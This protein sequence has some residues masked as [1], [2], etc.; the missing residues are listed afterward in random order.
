MSLLDQA[1]I[2]A[3]ELRETALRSAEQSILERYAPEVRKAVEGMLNEQEELGMEMGAEEGEDS[4]VEAP[5]AATEGEKLC[6]CPDEGEDVEVEIDF[7]E[8]EKKADEIEP[9]DAEELAVGL[10]AEEG[11]VGAAGEEEEEPFALQEDNEEDLPPVPSEEEEEEEED[12]FELSEKL[13]IDLD[14]VADG[15]GWFPPNPTRRKYAAEME[16]AKQQADEAK[17]EA[18]AAKDALENVTER[19]TIYSRTISSLKN[20][21][22]KNSQTILTLKQKNDKFSNAIL[23]LEGKIQELLLINSRLL[24][25][26]R[27]LESIS[28]N[29]RQKKHLVE[30]ISKSRSPEEAKTIFESLKNV[31]GSVSTQK[32]QPKSLREAVQIPFTKNTS[33][34][35]H[36]MQDDIKSRMQK[37]AGIQ[38]NNIIDN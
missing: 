38:N 27:V 35:E 18:E 3:K 4:D 36:S 15:T 2:D 9:M 37:L 16:L 34:R 32:R 6:P 7:A 26:N 30:A 5:L 21:N 28:L 29:E 25:A 1:I 24:Y 31:V 17:E 33:K 22:T 12:E 14:P 13:V 20:K 8:L 11:A 19:N 23:N 10:G